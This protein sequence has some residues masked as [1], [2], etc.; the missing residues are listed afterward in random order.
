MPA[1][2]PGDVQAIGPYR[3]VRR[4]ETHSFQQQYLVHSAEDDADY[5]L[6]T[7]SF[8]SQRADEDTIERYRRE[9]E[10]LTRLRHPNLPEVLDWGFHQQSIAWF[11]MPVLE[12]QRLSTVVQTAAPLG[13]ARVQP[14]VRQLLAALTALHQ[15]G[16]VHRDLTPQSL[17]LASDGTLRIVDFALIRLPQMLPLTATG[18]SFGD[19]HYT[20]PEQLA[21][22]KRADERA[23]LYSV[24]VIAYQLLSGH[25]PREAWPVDQRQVRLPVDPGRPL[26]EVAPTLPGAV[27]DWVGRLLRPARR[28]RPASAQMA[29][30]T[31]PAADV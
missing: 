17:H 29:L 6:R 10:V 13:W 24:G 4:L 12:G 25:L 1:N 23:D 19:A 26:A 5:V 20:A 18:T 3:V 27:L 21:D 9:C 22:A 14:L 11:V 30:D 15:A 31:L 8:S 16:V 2:L 28:D 7:V